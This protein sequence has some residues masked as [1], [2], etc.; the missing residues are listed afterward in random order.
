[1]QIVPLTPDRHEQVIEL[2]LRRCPHFDR[3][4]VAGPLQ[5]PGRT[6][7]ATWLVALDETGGLTAVGAQFHLVGEPE[8]RFIHTVVVDEP[9]VG[10]GVG[11]RLH[12]LLVERLPEHARVL[13]SMVSDSGTPLAVAQHW[14]FGVQQVSI[15]SRLDLSGIP[16]VALPADVTLETNHRLAFDDEPVV[17]AMLDASQTNPERERTGPMTLS[18]LRGMVSEESETR[19][20]GVLVRVAGEPAGICYGLING[21][22]AHVFYTGVDP[23]Y[24]GRGLAGLVKHGFHRAAAGA[25][26]RIATT[27]NEQHNT[28]IRHVNEALGYRTRLEEIWLVRPVG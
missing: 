1:M 18:Q 9:R 27:E 11:G 8:D 5:M 17:E 3:T 16:A 13:T 19:P 4:M 26:A 10:N 20:L 6:D 14:G 21:V 2:V 25:G 22:E 28:G 15:Q 23:T 24:R 7:H 12:A